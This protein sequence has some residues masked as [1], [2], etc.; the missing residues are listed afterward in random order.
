VS[1]PK[2]LSA[3]G[4]FNNF[5]ITAYAARKVEFLSFKDVKKRLASKPLTGHDDDFFTLFERGRSRFH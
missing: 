4:S 3:M 1:Y 5:T 2:L